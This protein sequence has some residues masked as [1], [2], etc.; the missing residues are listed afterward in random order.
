MKLRI[1]LSL[2]ILFFM[3]RINIS[4][5]Q[6]GPGPHWIDN[7][8][9]GIDQMFSGALVGIDV[10]TP[11]DCVQ[12]ASLIFNGPVFVKHLAPNNINPGDAICNMPSIISHPNPSVIPTEIIDATLNSSNGMI[13]R[14]G[15]PANSDLQP[16]TGA[17][18]EKSTD[19]T[20]GCSFFNVFF[21]IFVPAGL[22]GGNPALW[23]Y[24]QVPLR[25]EAE[26]LQVPPIGVTYI[27]PLNICIGLFTSP[28]LGQGILVTNLIQAEHHII[29]K[30][31]TLN[32]SAIIEG[33]FDPGS[34]IMVSDTVTVKL[35]N[36]ISPYSIVDSYKT[37]LNSN[38]FGMFYFSNIS[39]G[40]YYIDVTH[41]NSIETWS[42]LG[43]SFSNYTVSYDFTVSSNQAFGDNQK[44]VGNKWTIYS[45]DVNQDGTVDASDISLVDNDAY[46]SV[47]GYVNTD[48]NGDDFVD[49]TDLSIVDNNAY[50]SVI[51][52]IP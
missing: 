12:D 2:S 29:N 3:S 18:V 5:A 20:K 13:L 47:S 43:I 14:I 46:S 48:V 7:C 21:K 49:A 35:R 27:H 52:I 10:L 50:N 36:T 6:C 38:G 8:S 22:F 42:S 4:F 39:D 17:V 33:R 9:P 41:R 30:F 11:L 28:V 34:G 32:L 37:I 16:S 23:L 40:I 1:Y 25:I 44:F 19:S 45:G 24:N 31:Y 51:V 26:I 15:A